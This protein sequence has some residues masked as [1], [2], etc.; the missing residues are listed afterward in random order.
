MFIFSQI[1]IFIE[2]LRRLKKLFIF[3]SAVYIKVEPEVAAFNA[4]LE[5]AMNS[6][7]KKEDVNETLIVE[8]QNQIIETNDSIDE[9]AIN[10]KSSLDDKVS[11]C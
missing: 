5:P 11:N 10:E 9:L 3:V 4:K 8:K 2:I 1:G 6:F 7:V